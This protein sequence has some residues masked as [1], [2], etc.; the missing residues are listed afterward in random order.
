MWCSYFLYAPINIT[1]NCFG[2]LTDPDT[3]SDTD[4][5]MGSDTGPDTGPGTD[6]DPMLFA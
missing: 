3:A 4:Q 1:Q 6:P 5:D 2:V